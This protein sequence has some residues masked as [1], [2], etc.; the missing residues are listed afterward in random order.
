MGPN[1]PHVVIAGAGIAGLEA[2]LALRTLA[3]DRV[4]ISLVAAEPQML[5]RPVTVGEAFGR[6]QAR[7]F[8]V[9]EI[10]SPHDAAFVLDTVTGVD[11]QA[12]EA[13]TAS[14]TLVRYDALII[15]TG[16]HPTVTLPGALTF[17][18]RAEVP[19]LQSLLEDLVAGR[20]RS[21]AFTLTHPQAWSLPLYELAVMTAAHLREHGAAAPVSIITPE[22]SPLELFGPD[23]EQAIAPL[24]ATL[25]IRVRTLALPAA[26]K[27]RELVLVGA[28]SVAA[29]SV[30]TLPE[31]HG[32]ALDGL[33]A[34]GGGFLPVDARGRVRG[35]EDVYAAGDVTSFPIKQGGLAA[36]QADAVAT[37]IAILAGAPV[38]DEPFRPV[39]RGLLITGGAPVYLRAEPQRRHRPR[40][41]GVDSAWPPRPRDAAASE[42]SDQALWWPPAK[43]AGRYLAPYLA[44]AGHM[45]RDGAALRDRRP[46]SA[47]APET[48]ESHDALELA[49]L[50]ADGDASWADYTSALAALDA[51]EALEGAL[52]PEY[53]TKRRMWQRELAL[54]G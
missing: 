14:G 30:V 19:A 39:L 18:G 46:V 3:G 1:R 34:D 43:I 12:H 29:E 13:R 53:E 49:L 28:G 51:A 23:G 16:A 10:I 38:R 17:T 22:A 40:S 31:L 32:P 24:L 37:T 50:V 26:V 11:A 20:V 4:A 54:T 7:S 52:P 2:L 25:G 48:P 45:R 27:H 5:Y 41:V 21:V 9:T 35:V 15:A 47:P 8:P 33:P 36:Q 44:G 6:S 42:A